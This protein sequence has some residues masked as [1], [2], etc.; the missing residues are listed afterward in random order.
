MVK[1][2]KEDDVKRARHFLVNSAPHYHVTLYS[3]GTSDALSPPCIVLP[4]SMRYPPMYR[5]RGGGGGG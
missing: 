4:E 2:E 1:K 3:I 5:R